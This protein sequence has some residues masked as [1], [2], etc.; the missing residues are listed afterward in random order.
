MDLFL[1]K[2]DLH[3]VVYDHLRFSNSKDNGLK[4]STWECHECI[5]SETI[6][7]KGVK[8]YVPFRLRR[9]RDFRYFRED[10]LHLR[11]LKGRLRH[12]I[13]LREKKIV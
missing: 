12:S 2:T 10:M 3:A 5:P 13:P 8:H 11:N 4:L 6:V 9:A 1:L 7:L